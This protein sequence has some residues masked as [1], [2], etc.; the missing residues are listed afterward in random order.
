MQN[1]IIKDYQVKS[2]LGQGGM[3]TV[4]LAHD[5]KFQTNVAIKV[6]NKEYVHN[7]NIRKRFIAEAKN[8]FKMSHPNIIKVNDLIDDGDTVAFVMEYIEGETLKE[9]IERKGKLSV[10]EIK[11]L[12][13]QMLEAVGYVHD[14][15]LVH[16][17]IKPSNFMITQKGQVKLLDFGIA[18]TTDVTSSE[19]TQ[20]GTGIQMG[21]PLYMSPEQ[22]K[23]SKE[24]GASSD[25]YS[26]GVVLWQMVMGKKPYDSNTLS[27]PEIQ[28]SILK[29][30]LPITNT[31]W[32]TIIQKATE[33]EVLSR[34]ETCLAIKKA[35]GKLTKKSK[36]FKGEDKTVIEPSVIVEKESEVRK[37]KTVVEVQEN[38]KQKGK[39]I[40]KY[41]R[42]ILVIIAILLFIIYKNLP[43]SEED[44]CILKPFEDINKLHGYKCKDSIIIA[45]TYTETD[46]FKDGKARVSRND[47]LF[48]I[49]ESGKMIEFL[50]FVENKIEEISEDIVKNKFFDYLKNI[51]DDRELSNYTIKLGDLNGDNLLDAVVNFTLYPSVEERNE[52]GNS[53]LE[54]PGLI[55]FINTGKNLK[56][57]DHSESFGGI[58]GINL[59]LKNI[60]NG[61]II[62][63]G[64]DYQDSDAMCCPSLFVR[65]RIVLRNDKLV[66]LD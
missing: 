53:I 41:L 54:F 42:L 48:Y 35:I 45:A 22:V 56:I 55:T 27:S 36:V 61:V 3:A 33:K 40:N 6:L 16:R 58:K 24:V 64:K 28:V 2:E 66:D 7:D 26:L 11:N 57:V 23:S 44:T 10:A 32:D 62:L 30:L 15:K 5:I 63:E 25:I 38:L 21:T 52:I 46:D 49:D 50:G 39:N 19:Y 31:N 34:Y 43:K 18:K 47:S 8:M 20:T 14:Q 60:S 59:E 37:K 65:K 13:S 1:T 4:Y 17:D 51:S 9:Y 29:E 12:F